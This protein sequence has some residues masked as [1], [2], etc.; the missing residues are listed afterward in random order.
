[1][2]IEKM[3]DQ[4]CIA[5]GKRF[6]CY[7]GRGSARRGDIAICVGCGHVALFDADKDG[8]VFLRECNE[9]EVEE[10]KAHPV[11]EKV[12]QQIDMIKKRIGEN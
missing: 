3:N 11:W 5:C 2:V 8:N 6:E 10:L 7:F 9:T 1:M 4:F 12:Q